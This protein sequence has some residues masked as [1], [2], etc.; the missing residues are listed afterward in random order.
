MKRT[1][2]SKSHR[3]ERAL[4]KVPPKKT[5][6]RGP[7]PLDPGKDFGTPVRK[8]QP[9]AAP[10]PGP[11]PEPA[12][13]TG[14]QAQQEPAGQAAQATAADAPETKQHEEEILEEPT[15]LGDNK[16]KTPR[17]MRLPQMEDP[18]IE[19]LEELGMAYNDNMRQRL[20]YGAREVELK[21]E[22]LALMR[23]HGK[24]IYRHGQFEIERVVESETVKVRISKAVRVSDDAS[25]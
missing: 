2:K 4:P 18:A 21:K 1:H 15:P 11:A 13:S 6:R 20:A 16:S 10:A 14:D 25:S 12:G 3:V 22:I 19:D 9:T 17:Q 7:S 23:K 8:D 5:G 24:T